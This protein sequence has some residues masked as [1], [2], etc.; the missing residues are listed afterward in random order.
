MGREAEGRRWWWPALSTLA[1]LVTFTVI[2]WSRREVDLGTYLLGGAHAFSVELYQ[3]RYPVTHLGFTYPPFAALLF[4]P[5]AHLPLK[6]DTIAFDWLSLGSLFGLLAVCLRATAPSLTKRSV[7]WWS[8]VLM[9]PAV[10]LAPVRETIL[11][12]QINIL[13]ALAVLADMTL[14]LRIAKG[15][16]VG[17]AAAVKLTPIILVPYLFVTGRT[18]AG[19]TALATFAA[20]A[21]LAAVVSPHASWTY[22]SHDAW[23]PTRAGSIPYI[24]N[25]GAIG[26]VERLVRH[27]LTRLTTFTI[28]AAISGIGIVVARLAYF[29]SSLVLGLVVMEATEALASPVSWDHHLVWVVLLIAWLVLASDRPAHGTWWAAA[30]AILFWAAPIWWVPHNRVHY[31]GRG[32]LLPLA[33]SFFLALVAVVAA[34]GVRTVHLRQGRGIHPIHS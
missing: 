6:L 5:F 3:V 14:T 20:A 24:A 9:A 8:L 25:Q 32:W 12:G 34:A 1:T 11:F 27:P 17:L 13:L 10:L 19:W 22:W 28:V 33:D 4:A 16:L 18:R 21:V 7:V 29:R 23:F 26:V 30:V 15:V 2:A 31:A